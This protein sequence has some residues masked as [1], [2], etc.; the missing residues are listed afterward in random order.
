MIGEW[1]SEYLEDLCGYLNDLLERDG[2]AIN[3]LLVQKTAC[4]DALLDAP[5]TPC[6]PDGITPLGVLCGIGGYLPER[7]RTRICAWWDGEKVTS[8]FVADDET[9]PL[10]ERPE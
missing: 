5:D 10:I 4:N 7:Q 3:A 6:W 1:P 2:E 8:F 9:P